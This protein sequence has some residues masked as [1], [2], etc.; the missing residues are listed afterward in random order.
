[1][2]INVVAIACLLIRPYPLGAPNFAYR[3]V[4]VVSYL[5]MAITLAGNARQIALCTWNPATFIATLLA[6]SATVSLVGGESHTERDFLDVSRYFLIPLV[7]Q[8]GMSLSYAGS[9]MKSP[10]TRAI[11]ILAAINILFNL[12]Q[13]VI[14]HAVTPLMA[15]HCSDYRHILN[16][17][18]KHRTIGLFSNPNTNGILSVMFASHVIFVDRITAPVLRKMVFSGSCLSAVLASSRTSLILV[19]GL[20]AFLGLF[21]GNVFSR[22]VLYS[23]GA[24]AFPTF[25][26]FISSERLSLYVP[27]LA[28]FVHSLIEHGLEGVYKVNSFTARFDIWDDQLVHFYRSPV[29][30]GGPLR[31]DIFSFSDNFYIY[32]LCHYGLS[33]LMLFAGFVVAILAVGLALIAKRWDG[34]TDLGFHVFIMTATILVASFAM[35]AFTIPQIN[36]FYCVSIGM[37]L[38][39]YAVLSTFYLQQKCRKRVDQGFTRR[40]AA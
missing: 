37:V 12:A 6:L 38:H 27:Y 29:F 33:G 30:G 39:H 19:V 35:D 21:R 8:Y 20:L 9:M 26:A 28:Q 24:L 13:Y 2:L 16:V 10:F 7:V 32:I 5:V 15:L 23:V 4:D 1:M 18:E 36:S 3:L 17:Y 34:G 22:T 40:I 14:P 11:T 31:Q 25:F